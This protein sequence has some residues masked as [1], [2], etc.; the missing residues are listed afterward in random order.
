M[1]LFFCFSESLPCIH[2][3][4]YLLRG[5][6]VI[7]HL[8]VLLANE[9]LALS[10]WNHCLTR[11]AGLRERNWVALEHTA[12]MGYWSTIPGPTQTVSFLCLSGSPPTGRITAPMEHVGPPE[13]GPHLPWSVW[14]GLWGL[15]VWQVPRWG[16]SHWAGL[17]LGSSS[18]WVA[19][20][21]VSFHC[22]HPPHSLISL[23][24][25]ICHSSTNSSEEVATH[26]QNQ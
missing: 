15:Q 6:L 13:A 14:D 24:S 4:Q 21:I 22:L 17:H 12:R 23:F 20:I 1:F 11:R 10:E 25:C 16:L 9:E 5:P 2:P 8:A 19:K 7:P 26:H 18:R 3:H